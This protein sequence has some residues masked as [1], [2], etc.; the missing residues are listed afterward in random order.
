MKT[1]TKNQKAS[2]TSKATNSINPSVSERHSKRKLRY[3]LAKQLFT[4]IVSTINHSEKWSTE[5]NK[6]EIIKVIDRAYEMAE[7]FLNYV[8]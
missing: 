1:R 4:Q 8:R 3:E 2:K 5:I 7:T 6:Y